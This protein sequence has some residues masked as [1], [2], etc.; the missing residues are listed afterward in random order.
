MRRFTR[1]HA[2][3]L[4]VNL[5]TSFG[6]FD[7]PQENRTVLQNV[8]TSLKR[9]GVFVLDM[10]GKEILARILQPTSA[11][12]APGGEL[13]VRRCWVIEGWSRIDN[14]WL[15]ISAGDVRVFRLRH[16]LY[17]GYELKE[18][19]LSVGFS[20][21]QLYGSFEG[22]EYGPAANRL[23]AVAHKHEE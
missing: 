10:L 15:H 9:G 20:R 16:W 4:A 12:E 23:I 17:S 14:E 7:T 22:T 11:E 8:Y 21:V 18:L 1:P 13:L 2:F 5:F 19:L 3:D 6:Y